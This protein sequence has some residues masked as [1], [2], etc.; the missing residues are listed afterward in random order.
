MTSQ[1]FR[2]NEGGSIDRSR[3]ISFSFDGKSY[4]GHPGDTLAS[5]LIANGVHM[6]ARS[7]KYHRPRGIVGAG[8]EDPAGLVQIGSGATADPNTRATEQELWDGLQAHAQNCWPSLKHDLYAANDIVSRFYSA[9]FYYK[10]FMGPPGNWMTFEPIVRFAAG[11][12]KTPDGPDPDAY[13]TI[14]RHCDVLIVGA[15]PAGLMAALSAARSG[16]RVI[17]AEETAEAG[18]QLLSL[19]ESGDGAITIDDKTPRDWIAGALAE[20]ASNDRVTV[21]PR[22]SAIGY[23]A[24]NFVALWEKVSDHLAPKDR[25]PLLPRQR[26]WRI[27]AKE[28]VLATGAV[29][30]SLVFHEN[31]RPGIMLASAART[32]LHRYG[33][34]GGHCAA[35]IANNDAAWQTA[36]DLQAAGATISVISDS[37]HQPDDALVNKAAER[38]IPVRLAH[39]VAST[40]GRHR[41]KE[42][43]IESETGNIEGFDADLVAISGGWMPNVALFSQSRGQL[44]YDDDLAAFRP[45]WHWQRTHVCGSADGA[46]TMAECFSGGARVGAWAAE[47]AGCTANA[48]PVP[49]LANV[50]PEPTGISPIWQMVTT[51]GGKKAFVDLQDDVK[52]SDLE[53]AVRE[54]YRSVEH[55]KRYTTVG[56]GNDQGK[57]SNLNAFGIISGAQGKS[58]PELGTTTFRQPWKPVTFGAIA[59][60]FVGADFEPR[61]TTPMHDWHVRAEAIFEPVGDWL[62]ARAY[63]RPGET[64]EDAV[65]REVKAARTDVA[66]LDASTLGKIDIRGKDARTFLN[67]IYT[68]AWSKLAPGRCRY[69]LMLGEDAMVFDDGVTSCIADDHFHMTTTTG[70]AARVLTWLEDY[71]Q[72]EWPDLDVFLTTVTEETAVVSLSGPKSY[73]VVKAI[74]DD[75]GDLAPDDFP[76]MSWKD[77]AIDGVACRVFRISFTGELSYEINVPASYGLWLWEKVMEAG[78]PFGITPYGTEGMHLLR[79]EKGFIIVGQDT[80]GTITPFD[81][82]M[83][84]IVSQKKGDFVGKRSLYRSDTVRTNRKQLVGLLTEDPATVL[85]EGAQIIATPDEP[86]P[87]VPMLGYVT[88]SYFSPNLG[89]SI[90]MALVESGGARIGETVYIS[91]KGA[92]PLAATVTETDFLAH[93]AEK[94]DG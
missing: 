27:R 79:A 36:F 59:G 94:A 64:F 53:L 61:R 37:R 43:T 67:R 12:G 89:R 48:A 13:E 93:F 90:A 34:L 26:L 20:L 47:A 6:V 77:A 41:V 65:Q 23:Y 28:V 39:Q 35:V 16:A 18:G 88:S 25:N 46:M 66:V 86:A 57:I 83:D 10:T 58:L 8:A 55:A 9:G 75:A 72:T 21:L 31:D 60:Q 1:P 22:T 38:D 54:G 82:R 71:L 85:M 24:D 68:N 40:G 7:F 56:M 3:E 69:G 73:D 45:G 5:A 50:G 62:R 80:D 52:A 76:F 42:I 91:R 84:W 63:P 87:P 32:Y 92:K 51:E 14:N 70:G 81:L 4:A 19:P 2:L 11:I 17:L 15:G 30:R 44:R 78:A 33:A 74:C 49:E 29:E